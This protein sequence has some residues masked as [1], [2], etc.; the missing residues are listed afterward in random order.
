MRTIRGVLEI[1]EQ[2]GVVYFTGEP[3]PAS[4]F[5][6]RICQLPKPVPEGVTYID[7]TVGVG[8]E[9]ADERNAY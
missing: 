3:G 1:D 6:L 5:R 7:V 4:W 9:Y 2:R 8:A